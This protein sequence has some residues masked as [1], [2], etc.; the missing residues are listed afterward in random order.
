MSDVSAAFCTNSRL[1]GALQ[2]TTRKGNWSS[3]FSV[4]FTSETIL[5]NEKTWIMMEDL[6]DQSV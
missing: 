3:R 6:L 4:P 1:D 2:L 5:N